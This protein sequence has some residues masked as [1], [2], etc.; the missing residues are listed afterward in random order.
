MA[1][2][3]YATREILFKVV[4]CGPA[5]SGKTTNMECLHSM[6]EPMRRGK[7]LSLWTGTDRMVSF[8]I[9]PERP[10]KPENRE[11]GRKFSVGF[12]LYTVPGQLKDGGSWKT[13]LKGVDAIVFVAD[14]QRRMRAAN[15]ES[16]ENM[17]KSLLSEKIIPMDIPMVLEFNKRD[18]DDIL[19]AEELN[20][21]LNKTGYPYAEAVAL[22]GRAVK[23]TFQAVAKQLTKQAA[24]AH[25]GGPS[26][27]RDSLVRAMK[28][29]PA[30]V[31]AN[32][33]ARAV[34]GD[35]NK[36]GYGGI[37]A[38][39]TAGRPEEVRRGSAV[40]QKAMTLMELRSREA[41]RAPGFFGRAKLF[42]KGMKLRSYSLILAVMLAAL[43]ITY[44]LIR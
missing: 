34:R 10:E 13:V 41:E 12:Q 18:M 5:F 8:D 17:Y 32:E 29:A 42:A 43:F 3:N 6:I 15:V 37:T 35:A 36:G 31:G 26:P 9:L 28:S 20:A 21:D 14:S 39:E 44:M 16:L 38:G 27:A 11:K 4:Y 23:E 2:L 25:L 22:R 7:L 19:T 24:K 40:P 33:D 1:L 30:K